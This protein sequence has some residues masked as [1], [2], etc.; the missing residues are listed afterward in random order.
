MFRTAIEQDKQLALEPVLDLCKWVVH[1]ATSADAFDNTLDA[2]L[3]G[4]S[5]WRYTLDAVVR[6]AEA[7]CKKKVPIH[8]REDIWAILP[9]VTL[10]P[11]ESYIID[12]NVQQDGRKRDFTTESLNT[13][14][15]RVLHGIFEYARWVHDHLVARGQTPT[16][17]SAMPEV[18]KL[19]N[20]E[21]D[22]NQSHSYAVR[23]TFGWWFVPLYVIDTH[24]VTEHVHRIFDLGGTAGDVQL[25]QPAK[26]VSHIFPELLFLAFHVSEAVDPG[27][28]TLD[29]DHRSAID[30]EPVW[31]LPLS[32]VIG[33]AN[34]VL[35][36]QLVR[37]SERPQQTPDVR[38]QHVP[39]EFVERISEAVPHMVVDPGRHAVGEQCRHGGEHPIRADRFGIGP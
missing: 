37:P 1:H 8:Y 24:W 21:L 30:D 2:D 36:K 15:S 32:G 23:S 27:R 6:F 25:P 29:Q 22:P 17:L 26:D 3:R 38:T 10:E 31:H 20:D 35:R 16:D 19:L 5:N 9:P 4:E 18:M 39:E 14:R 12:L 11:E 33:G 13:P 28:L 7:L 34:I